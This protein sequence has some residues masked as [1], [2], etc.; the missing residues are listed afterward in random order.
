MTAAP[1]ES[2]ERPRAVRVLLRW[3]AAIVLVPLVAGLLLAGSVGAEKLWADLPAKP[4]PAVQLTCWN[5]EEGT[6]CPEP[7]GV[8]GL[9]WV[10]PSFRPGLRTCREVARAGAGQERPLEWA[11]RARL[12]GS[13]VVITY[14]VR[15]STQAGLG[16]LR[17]TVTPRPTRTEDGDHLVFATTKPGPDGR[18]AVTVA[19]ADHPFTVTASAVTLRLCNLALDELVQLRDADQVLVR[20]A[21]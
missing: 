10:F 21:P 13:D 20:S 9:R 4:E 5:G 2:S 12:D 3:R 8:K 1:P 19:Y 15:T 14:T 18:F 17:R 11:C 16:Y 6:D 7:A